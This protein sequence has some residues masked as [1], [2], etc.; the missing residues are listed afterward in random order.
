MGYIRSNEEYD[1][2]TE[3]ENRDPWGSP[4]KNPPKQ[5]W[6]AYCGIYSDH[7]SGWCPKIT[8]H[9]YGINWHSGETRLLFRS[10]DYAAAC[11]VISNHKRIYFITRRQ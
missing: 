5:L 10:Y 9:G 2:I 6:C 7:Q 3:N 11:R 1:L 8:R 4:I